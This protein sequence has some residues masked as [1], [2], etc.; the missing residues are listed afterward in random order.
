MK[1]FALEASLNK[2]VLG[3]YPQIKGF[4][5]HCDVEEEANFIDKFIFEKI[6]IQPVL[7]NVVLHSKS[8]LTDFID[9]FGDIGFNFSYIISSR[10]KNILDQ[11]NTFGFQYF[12]TY[13]IQNN[14]N[15]EN[16][17]QTNI[18]VFPFNFIDFEK[19]NFILKD[20]DINRNV[21][22]ETI[23]FNN[24]NEFNLFVCK[25]K[26][27]KMI[28][29]KNIFFNENMNLDFFVLRYTEGGHKG[30]VSERLKNELEKNEIS[31]IEFRPIEISFSDWIIS[32][33]ER[34]KI[35]GKSL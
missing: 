35:Y 19:S 12:K 2:K 25:V 26:Y 7:S 20:R 28:S 6:E 23:N 13:I 11:F 34:E 30:I 32:G 27:P 31:G 9:T 33:G 17:W 29:F 24:I 16:Y 10:F 5:H 22:I 15:F 8:N 4:L 1:Y 14:K 18:Y 3:N 21:I